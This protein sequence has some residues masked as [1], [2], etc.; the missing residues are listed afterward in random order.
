MLIKNTVN[1][2]LLQNIATIYL[3][4][5]CIQL[6]FFEGYGV[7]KIKVPLM[8]LSPLL[9][10]ITV[11]YFSKAFF[12]GGFYVVWVFF[13]TILLQST[14]RIETMG[15]MAMFVSMYIMFYNMVYAGAFNTDFFIR[16]MK[17]LIGAY[18]IVLI[19]QHL[20]S[21]AGISSMPIL[22]HYA[23][24]Q[25]I[26]KCQSLSMEVSHSARVLTAA[27]YAFLKTNEI[28]DGRP[29]SVQE[30]FVDN[31]FTTYGFLYAMILMF[32]STAIIGLILIAFYFIK[33]QYFI[34]MIAL[35]VLLYFTLPMIDYEPLQRAITIAKATMTGD[36]Q[37]IIDADSSA[38][39]RVLPL[40]NTLNLDITRY[41]T[42]FGQGVDTMKS[43]ELYSSN[44]VVGGITDYGLIS[45]IIGL[46]F[47]YSCCIRRVFSIETLIFIFLLGAGGIT[48]IAYNWGILMI[49]T[50]IKYF[51]WRNKQDSQN[52]VALINGSNSKTTSQG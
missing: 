35:S 51:D 41:D 6:V 17:G 13:C 44:W 52:N 4:A 1:Q 23:F 24:G 29:M 42:W 43:S 10:L 3:V 50:V 40:I 49:F 16:L 28:K 39:V 9:L 7:S 32:S 27:F 2:K 22:N 36:T 20:L 11:P 19:L 46:L 12:W 33:K 15:Y 38:A 47:V 37:E 45:Y 48:N 5:M 21:L 31:K 14:P 18:V 30:L 34:P 26:F 25:S 8:C